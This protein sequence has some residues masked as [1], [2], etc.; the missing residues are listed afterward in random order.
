MRNCNEVLSRNHHDV[1]GFFQYKTPYNHD[2]QRL[3]VQHVVDQKEKV[4]Y[5]KHDILFR[6]ER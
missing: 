1:Q 6:H 5:L 2:E 4:S 3:M